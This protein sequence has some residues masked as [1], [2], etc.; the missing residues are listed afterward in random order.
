MLMLLDI[1]LL[2]NK[3]HA[4]DYHMPLKIIYSYVILEILDDQSKIYDRSQRPDRIIPDQ[5][6]RYSLN[7]MNR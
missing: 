4:T 1:K 3:G 2:L 6:H 5:T 7:G